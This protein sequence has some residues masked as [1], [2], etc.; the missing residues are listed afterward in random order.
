MSLKH[1]D[2]YLSCVTQLSHYMI[3]LILI[4]WDVFFAYS[5]LVEIKIKGELTWCSDKIW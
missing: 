1:V 2:E 3:V 5:S 4:I